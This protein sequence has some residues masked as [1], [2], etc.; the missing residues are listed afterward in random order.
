MAHGFTA[1]TGAVPNGVCDCRD[2]A[3]LMREAIEGRLGQSC[4]N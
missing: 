1:F 2:V 4:L 3:G